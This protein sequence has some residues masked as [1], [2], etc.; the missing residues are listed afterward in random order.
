MT[1][2]A[3]LLGGHRMAWVAS[4]VLTSALF[5]W[6]HTEQGISGWIQEA[7]SGFLLGTLFLLAGRNLVAPIVAHGVSNTLAF[8][9]IYLGRYPAM[10]E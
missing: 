6:G 1:R 8:I 5:G 3:A 7:L 2:I 10:L 4:L 9:L